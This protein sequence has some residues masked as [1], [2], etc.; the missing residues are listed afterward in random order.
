MFIKEQEG[1]RFLHKDW[2]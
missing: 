1:H 2:N